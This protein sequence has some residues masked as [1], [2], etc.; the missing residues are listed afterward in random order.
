MCEGQKLVHQSAQRRLT[1]Q[2]QCP[3]RAHVVLQHRHQLERYYRP[4]LAADDLLESH[5]QRPARPFCDAVQR[6]NKHVPDSAFELPYLRWLVNSHRS[7]SF[8]C[9][10]LMRT[11]PVGSDTRRESAVG[12][13]ANNMCVENVMDC[14]LPEQST[15]AARAARAPRR[16]TGAPMPACHCRQ[17]AHIVTSHIASRVPC[18]SQWIVAVQLNGPWCACDTAS[19]QRI[20]ERP[21]DR[22]PP[23]RAQLVQ[24]IPASHVCIITS[25]DNT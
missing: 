18:I 11:G 17:H 7:S 14:L 25:H 6:L 9:S 13:K 3:Q 20:N 24:H 12:C 4:R 5:F 16:H 23:R 10:A 19:R 8:R 15:A 1:R 21:H 2:H 22:R